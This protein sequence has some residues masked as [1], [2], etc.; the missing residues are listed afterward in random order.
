MEDVI[1]GWAKASGSPPLAWVR[2]LSGWAHVRNI[3]DLKIGLLNTLMIDQLV[4]KNIPYA[5]IENNGTPVTLPQLGLYPQKDQKYKSADVDLF[6]YLAQLALSATATLPTTRATVEQLPFHPQD[7]WNCFASMRTI[8]QTME[9]YWQ[10]LTVYV[11]PNL[12]ITQ[13]SSEVR[14]VYRGPNPNPQDPR[15][16]FLPLSTDPDTTRFVRDL[17]KRSAPQDILHRD[18]VTITTLALQTIRHFGIDIGKVELPSPFVEN[19]PDGEVAFTKLMV[20]F[21]ELL[22]KFI[23]YKDFALCLIEPINPRRE[24]LAI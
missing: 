4:S 17:I 20:S 5:V 18:L 3:L 10:P 8:P 16:K 11:C 7:D 13:N 24:V 12:P 2:D 9:A 14:Q 1:L 15:H 19:K 22:G 6:D 21:F 23:G